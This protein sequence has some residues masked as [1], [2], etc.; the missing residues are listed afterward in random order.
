MNRFPWIAGTKTHV[1]HK[2]EDECLQKTDEPK[3]EFGICTETELYP[4]AKDMKGCNY[5]MALFTDHFMCTSWPFLDDKQ[6]DVAQDNN[7]TNFPINPK[8]IS[9]LLE[10]RIFGEKREL[11][12]H[13]SMLNSC[14]NWRIAD[15]EVLA[16]AVKTEEKITEGKSIPYFNNPEN[17]R[18]ESIQMLDIDSTFDPSTNTAFASKYG[19]RSLR[20]TGGGLYEL[21]ISAGENA[22]VL[23]SYIEYGDNGVANIADYRMKKFI[24]EGKFGIIKGGDKG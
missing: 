16:D 7:G 18:M 6:T 20:T 14:F 24:K 23:V 3:P 17:Y 19:G 21:P 4:L 11:W 8:D 12:V 9:Q 5:C 15:D 13:R 1:H 10:L 22:I 2:F